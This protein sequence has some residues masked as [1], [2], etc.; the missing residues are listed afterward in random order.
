M[1][2]FGVVTDCHYHPTTHPDTP[3]K[4]TSF[5]ADMEAWQPDFIIQLGDFVDVGWVESEWDAVANV[6]NGFSGD[7]YHV[8]GNHEYQLFYD[9]AQ[10]GGQEAWLARNGYSKAYYS[11]DSGDYKCIVLSTNEDEDGAG[12][13]TAWH[14]G[15]IGPTQRAWLISELEGT[16]KKTVIFSH[17]R[18]DG[19]VSGDSV[20]GRWLANSNQIRGILEKHGNVVA[21]FSGHD[22][23]PDKRLGY[24]KPYY[25]M[26]SLLNATAPLYPHSKVTIDGDAVSIETHDCSGEYSITERLNVSNITINGTIS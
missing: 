25:S 11:F 24:R 17:A 7:K 12:Y 22:H 3:S 10:V 16:T 23:Q 21:I 2:K 9:E 6:F 19:P 18:I 13:A 5:V 14:N 8:L 20:Q 26:N 4:L 1:L 15:F